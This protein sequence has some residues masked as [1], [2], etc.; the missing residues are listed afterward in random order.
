MLPE[1]IRIL[2]SS[3]LNAWLAQSWSRSMR[4]GRSPSSSSRSDPVPT[5]KEPRGGEGESRRDAPRR[6]G[7]ERG[8]PRS[9]EL[10]DGTDRTNANRDEGR[11]ETQGRLSSRFALREARIISRSRA[12]PHPRGEE[13]DEEEDEE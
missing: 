5:R 10:F 12:A 3:S 6:G 13:E 4:A 8:G 11:S 9:D 7:L 2:D 1:L